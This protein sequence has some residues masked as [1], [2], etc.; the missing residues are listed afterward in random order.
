MEIGTTKAPAGLWYLTLQRKGGKFLLQL[1]DPASVRRQRIDAFNCSKLEG[2]IDI[3]V[4]Q[5]LAKPCQ[6]HRNVG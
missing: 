5:L 3:E 4:R 1:H 2:G 6:R